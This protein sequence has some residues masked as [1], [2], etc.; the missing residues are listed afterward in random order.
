MRHS[1][2]RFPTAVG[3][4]ISVL[5]ALAATGCSDS[6]HA[7]GT[8]T[9]TVSINGTAVEA[10]PKIRCHQAQWTWFIETLDKS[11]GFQAQV[12]TGNTVEAK[13]IR[14]DDLGGFTGSAW[15]DEGTPVGAQATLVDGTMTIS[16]VATGYF[17]DAPA[18]TT[19]TPFEIRT[20]C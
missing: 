16:G 17:R 2:V 11:P 14:I 5:A 7:L 8:H 1:H 19:T 9:A 4:T 3:A 12:Q 10:T 18:D 20:D 15:Q 6:F 13:L